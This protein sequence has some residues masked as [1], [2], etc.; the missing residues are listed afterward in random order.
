MSEPDFVRIWR[1]HDAIPQYALGHAAL[2]ATA[3]ADLV[4]HPGLH[5]IGHTLRGVGLNDCIAAAAALA[6]QI[7]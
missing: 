2:V 1:H 4:G 6:R 5:L 7:S 3:D